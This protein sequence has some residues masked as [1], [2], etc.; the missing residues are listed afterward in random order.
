MYYQELIKKLASN[1]GSELLF[2]EYLVSKKLREVV[3]GISIYDIE[4]TSLMDGSSERFETLHKL[5]VNCLNNLTSQGL[6]RCISCGT[7]TSDNYY[8]NEEDGVVL[9]GIGCLTNYMN[10]SFGKGNWCFASMILDNANLDNG[11]IL[12]KVN[13]SE[14]SDVL[15]NGEEWRYVDI[16][17][18]HDPAFDDF[19]WN[20]DSMEDLFSGN[21]FSF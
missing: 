12:A 15:I 8:Y 4:V 5:D 18:I 6:K 17:V 21:D 20:E 9:C 7:V 16:K 14:Y 13:D 1:K 3:G 2:G 19:V 10:N 11:M